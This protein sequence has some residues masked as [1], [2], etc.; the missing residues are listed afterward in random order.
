MD[1]DLNEMKC[2]CGNTKTSPLITAKT[3]YSKMGL[4]WLSMAYS[5]K[6]IEVVFQCQTCG[7]IIDRTDDPE[8]IEKYRYN[9]DILHE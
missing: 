9:S 2:S 6:P 3:R 8:V 7:D 1:K 5:A 4:F